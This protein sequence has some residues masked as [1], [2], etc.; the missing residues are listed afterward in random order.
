MTSGIIIEQRKI[1]LTEVNYSDGS[2]S[3]L[4]PI[5]IVSNDPEARTQE[6]QLSYFEDY[7]QNTY[8]PKRKI[9]GGRTIERLVEDRNEYV[10]SPE[11]IKA[12]KVIEKYWEDLAKAKKHS[13]H[14]KYVE[15]LRAVPRFNYAKGEASLL[16]IYNCSLRENNQ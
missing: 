8:L 13:D 15:L 12:E 4:R 6:A 2:G 7:Y 10:N 11:V 16:Y 1:F 3:K 5:V 14:H 9:S